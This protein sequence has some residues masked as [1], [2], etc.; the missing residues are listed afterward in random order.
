ME[1]AISQEGNDRAAI[2][3]GGVEGTRKS[4]EAVREKITSGQHVR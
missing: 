3:C 1:G 4:Q 2:L